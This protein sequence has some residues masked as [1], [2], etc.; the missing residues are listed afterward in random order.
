MPNPICN[1]L[2][3]RQRKATAIRIIGKVKTQ[4]KVNASL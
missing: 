3:I 4:E 2:K 1:P